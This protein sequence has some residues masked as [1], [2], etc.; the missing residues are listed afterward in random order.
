MSEPG[1]STFKAICI[2]AGK[3]RLSYLHLGYR[4]K[5]SKQL[6]IRMFGAMAKKC[7]LVAAVLDTWVGYLAVASSSAMGCSILP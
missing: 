7:R 2:E 5:S 6:Q 4:M 1:A 3:M